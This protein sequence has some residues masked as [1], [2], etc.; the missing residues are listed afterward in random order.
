MSSKK[1][2]ESGY[3]LDLDLLTILYEFIAGFVS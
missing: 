1:H 2:E 3:A